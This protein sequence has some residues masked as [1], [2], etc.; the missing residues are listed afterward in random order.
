M[1]S[2]SVSWGDWEPYCC[3]AT[4]DGL[5]AKVATEEEEEVGVRPGQV[6]VRLRDG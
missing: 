1:E 5:A 2:R 3:W 6:L 4:E